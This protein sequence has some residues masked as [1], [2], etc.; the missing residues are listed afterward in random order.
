MRGLP[1]PVLEFPPDIERQEVKVIRREMP[2]QRSSERPA[3]ITKRCGAR[4]KEFPR[5][6]GCD[7]A[8]DLILDTGAVSQLAIDRK[9]GI[10]VRF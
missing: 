10:T 8:V 4:V 9:D 1:R 2:L 7:V 3:A 5:G 6:A